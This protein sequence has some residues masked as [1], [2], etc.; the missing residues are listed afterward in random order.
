MA[1]LIW[2]GPG[3]N[4]SS[5]ANWVGGLAPSQDDHLVFPAGAAATLTNDF[6][7]G[8]RFRSITISDGYTI[9]GTNA[10]TLLEGVHFNSSSASATP[11]SHTA[12]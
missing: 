8:T 6:A 11:T 5:A 4:L 2:Q 1:T 3:T 12:A 9:Q 10:I 7:A